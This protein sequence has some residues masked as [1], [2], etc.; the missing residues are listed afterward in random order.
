MLNAAR[1]GNIDEA[2]N[3]LDEGTDPSTKD[4]SEF[5][6]LHHAAKGGKVSVVE[7]L[8]GYGADP[9]AKE[10]S[11]S[12][13]LHYAAQDGHNEI[14]QLLLEY[15][16][17]PNSK[18]NNGLTPLHIA[19]KGKKVFMVKLLLDAGADAVV[20]DNKGNTSLHIATEPEITRLLLGEPMIISQQVSRKNIKQRFLSLR[21][22]R[23][24]L[25]K[26]LGK[27]YT[28]ISHHNQRE[29][30]RPVYTKCWTTR[31]QIH[32]GPELGTSQFI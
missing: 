4:P 15:W 2:R 19:A 8:L 31:D 16:A 14:I 29:Y 3:L 7:L 9:N 18:D 17:D 28:I 12:A 1:R 13:S 25:I 21:N 24:G 20:Q 27:R 5:T 10:N 26:H 11:G 32:I 30:T 22:L 23:L 6:P